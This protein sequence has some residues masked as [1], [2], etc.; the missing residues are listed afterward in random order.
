[1]TKSGMIRLNDVRNFLKSKGYVNILQ[2]L[3]AK[4]HTH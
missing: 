3:Y 4:N 2:I 1:M